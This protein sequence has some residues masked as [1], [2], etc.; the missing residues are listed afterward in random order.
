MEPTISGKKKPSLT[1]AV[2]LLAG[3]FYAGFAFGKAGR[4]PAESIPELSGKESPPMLSVATDFSPFWSAWNVLNDKYVPATTT[5][6]A[7]DEQKLWGAIEGLTAAFK[8]PYTVFFPPEESKLFES[9]ISGSFDGV[10]ME[11]GIKDDVLTVVAPLK[12]TPAEHAGILPGDKILKINDEASVNMRVDQ[13]VKLIRGKKGTQVRLTLLRAGK[14]ESFEVSVTRDTIDIPTIDAELKPGKVAFGEADKGSGFRSD[15][16]FIIRLYNFSASSPRLFQ[17]ALREFVESGSNKLL[18]DLRGNPG[19]FLEAAV[20]IASWFLPAGKVVVTEDGGARVGK[21]VHRSRGYN[22]F[23]SNLK[24]VILV[25]AGSASA[26]EIL[27]G[28]LSEHGVATLVGGKTFGKGSVQELVKLTPETSL[29]VTVARWF[30]P[31]G[32]SIS[33]GGLSPDVEVKM[34]LEDM[35]KKR[36]PQMDKAIELLMKP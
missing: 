35:E 1:L 9:E 32:V 24:M 2:I 18:L 15:D 23:R 29:K 27:A 16:V 22:V 21:R 7:S 36:D 5:A 10:G 8:D 12:G 20:D 26:S 14:T 31:D 28:A 33:D 13:A 34:T 4:P 3:V 25:N 17:Q 6:I 19:G 30:T 11:I